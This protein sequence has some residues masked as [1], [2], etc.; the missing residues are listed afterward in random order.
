MHLASSLLYSQNAP[1][2]LVNVGSRCSHNQRVQG[3][4]VKSLLAHAVGGNQDLLGAAVLGAHLGFHRL[5]EDTCLLLQVV[6]QSIQ[7]VLAVLDSVGQHQYLA[8]ILNDVRKNPNQ[9]ACSVFAGSQL[10]H[11]D[12]HRHH[13]LR[14]HH[15]FIELRVVVF[16]LVHLH[17]HLDVHG[18]ARVGLVQQRTEEP[19]D[20]EH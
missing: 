6:R 20:G 18:I 16:V 12:G 8:S 4:D 2:N 10:V 1:D 5:A 19:M 3:R 9:P 15:D 14:R 11:H 17:V 7:Q 13:P